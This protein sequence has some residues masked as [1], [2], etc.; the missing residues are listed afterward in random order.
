[1][2][3]CIFIIFAIESPRFKNHH[4]GDF[5]KGIFRY[6]YFNACVRIVVLREEKRAVRGPEVRKS[7]RRGLATAVA[8]ISKPSLMNQDAHE[9][10]ENKTSREGFEPSTTRFHLRIASMQ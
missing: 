1:M 9:V 5:D 3:L 6:D 7:E 2:S 10:H 8:W 4:P